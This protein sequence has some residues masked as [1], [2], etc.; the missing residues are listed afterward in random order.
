M[1]VKREVWVD[2]VKVIACI[3]VVLGHFFQ[4]MVKADILPD[5]ALY[6]WFNTAIY[7]FHVPLFF[8]CSG[9]LYQRYGKVNSWRTW[10]SNV[11]K[12]AISLG[13]PYF[14]FSFL[15][16]L[17]KTIFSGAVNDQIGGLS[18]TLFIHP[19]SPYWY[20]YILFFLFLI[21]PT[22]RQKK[23]AAVLLL[24]AAAVKLITFAFYE[25]L[26]FYIVRAT[27][28]NWI[29]FVLGIV[30]SSYG[31]ERLNKKALGALLGA[32][33]LGISVFAYRTA[34]G[35]AAFLLGLMACAAVLMIVYGSYGDTG[36]RK[37]NLL[38][39]AAPYTMPVFLMHTL[40][41]ATFRS[42]LL[43]IGL[44]NEFVHVGGGIAV[45]FIGPVV[46]IHFLEKI[47]LDFLVYPKQLK[48]KG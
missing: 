35:F 45:S 28:S 47:K 46:A 25:E 9:Y 17:L 22:A 14:S 13:I 23:D 4:S 12:K 7:Y 21:T 30:L 11:C 20:L 26:R 5:N 38:D 39:A 3:L 32:G 31:P 8:I 10:Q 40:F 34:A 19:M 48:R 1:S 2:Y 18:E 15:T 36:E 43:R 42:L 37:S 44:I 27:L 16:W 24:I 29:W 41:A 33:F 6:E